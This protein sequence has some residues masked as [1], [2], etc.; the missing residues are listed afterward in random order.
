[1]RNCQQ[2]MWAVDPDDS[3]VRCMHGD[4]AGQPRARPERQPG[5]KPSRRA[6][7]WR[8]Q[9]RA[10]GGSVAG[11]WA[12]GG[13]SVGRQVGRYPGGSR[14][15]LAAVSASPAPELAA[16]TPAWRPES[17]APAPMP[18]SAA[19]PPAD[20][21]GPQL[22]ACRPSGPAA[23]R[24]PT[25]RARSSTPPTFWARSL[26]ARARV[27]RL[28]TSEHPGLPRSPPR[29][30]AQVCGDVH[31]SRMVGPCSGATRGSNRGPGKSVPLEVRL[32]GTGRPRLLCRGAVAEL[33]R[34][35]HSD[36]SIF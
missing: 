28:R 19:S 15:R 33:R 5:R 13:A 36:D 29:D 21:P 6:G 3:G 18:K 30:G 11:R 35:L 34:P 31:A 4:D 16:S 22:R 32:T 10:D 20:L 27:R 23:P 14:G 17:T 24:L 8:N 26:G 9:W 1:M 7:R 2:A 25:F 12:V